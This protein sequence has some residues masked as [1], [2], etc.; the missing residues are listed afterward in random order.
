MRTISAVW[1]SW[2]PSPQL[3]TFSNALHFD[4]SIVLFSGIP[5]FIARSEIAK[6]P[7]ICCKNVQGP[8]QRRWWE[9]TDHQGAVHHAE[10][11][12]TPGT[13]CYF[14]FFQRPT[15]IQKIHEHIQ[16]IYIFSGLF[17]NSLKS[18]NMTR[19]DTFQQKSCLMWVF[20]DVKEM[21]LYYINKYYRFFLWKVAH[22]PWKWTY[23]SWKF[24]TRML[25]RWCSVWERKWAR[26][27]RW[28][29]SGKLIWT[30][31]AG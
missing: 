2:G 11:N 8:K 18:S 9:D 1:S 23:L 30:A 7:N 3:R 6:Y 29:R 10:V 4:C 12:N 15:L 26:K 16:Y 31:T 17:V 24:G 20:F 22:F 28:R 5:M 13:N 25:C 21:W 14:K 19:M 27:K